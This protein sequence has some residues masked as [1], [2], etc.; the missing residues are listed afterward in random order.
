MG[1]VVYTHNIDALLHYILYIIQYIYILGVQKYMQM[2]QKNVYYYWYPYLL[3]LE[4]DC[5]P[6]PPFPRMNMFPLKGQVT[7]F[8][9]KLRIYALRSYVKK[10]P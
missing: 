4:F 7:D 6:L 1:F 8:E 2:K 3:L 5:N 9:V 10:Y